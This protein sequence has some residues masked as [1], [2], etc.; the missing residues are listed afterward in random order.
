MN[1]KE[2]LNE[3]VNDEMTSEE[4]MN[5]YSNKNFFVHCE[6]ENLKIIVDDFLCSFDKI[7]SFRGLDNLEKI[8]GN[9][10]C[11]NNQ[12]ISFEGLKN[13][14]LIRGV[15]TCSNNQLTS[16]KGLEKLEEIKGNLYCNDN[17]LNS[18]E[19]LNKKII[20]RGLINIENNPIKIGKW[21][22]NYKILCHNTIFDKEIQELVDYYLDGTLIERNKDLKF[23][24]DNKQY[25]DQEYLDLI[26]KYR[27][28]D[29]QEHSEYDDF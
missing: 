16:F 20:I 28:I 12:L 6:L 17:K 13:L 15:F 26:N 7:Q 14:K 11:N 29:K 19:G 4:V 22:N 1:F 5:C 23:F 10:F 24:I 21:I 18:F 2:F 3:S 9:F 27:G 8:F 25:Y